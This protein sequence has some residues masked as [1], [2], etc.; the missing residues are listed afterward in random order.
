MDI[1]FHN[2][3]IMATFSVMWLTGGKCIKKSMYTQRICAIVF[4]FDPQEAKGY[5]CGKIGFTFVK[6]VIVT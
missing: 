1:C 2:H 6:E 5:L 3:L 4:L